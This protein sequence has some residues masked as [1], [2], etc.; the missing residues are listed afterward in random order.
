MADNTNDK[1]GGGGLITANRVAALTGI[2]LAVIAFLTT[3]QSS[4][5]PGSPAG[6]AIAKA[7][8]ML[9]SV[10]TVLRI[11]DKFLDG[12]QNWDSLLMA[13]VPKVTGV[14]APDKGNQ[15]GGGVDEF[16]ADLDA[17]GR[18]A[19]AEAQGDFGGEPPARVVDVSDGVDAPPLK[20]PPGEG[21]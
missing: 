6:E 4:F 13:G 8:V 5:I 2:V 11:V 10:L 20:A 12:S 18:A 9:T 14:A 3:L 7:L 17:E 21:R 1:T 16:D 19:F 15:L